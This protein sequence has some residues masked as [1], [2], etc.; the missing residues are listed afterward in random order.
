MAQ[1]RPITGR[2]VAMWFVAF[3]GIVIAVNLLMA[4]LAIGTFGGTVVDNSYVASQRYNEWLAA[5]RVQA[6]LG[7]SVTAERGPSGHVVVQLLGRDG[8]AVPGAT[9]NVV[10][11]HPLGGAADRP[12]HFAGADGRFVSTAPLPAGRWQLRIEAS[13]GADHFRALHEIL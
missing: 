11:S 4:R 8:R 5:G 1:R 13:K 2:R 6:A 9:I 7:W 12:M 3:F 10:A